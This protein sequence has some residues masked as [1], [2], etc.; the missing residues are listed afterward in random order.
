MPIGSKQSVSLAIVCLL[1][2][3][4]RMGN[5]K[6]NNVICKNSYLSDLG[7]K[8]SWNNFNDVCA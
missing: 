5:T 2:S 8:K 1:D 3:I 4:Q 7:W 6:T